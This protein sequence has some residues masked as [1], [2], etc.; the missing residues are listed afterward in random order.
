MLVHTSYKTIPFLIEYM[1]KK[2]EKKAYDTI[3][4]DRSELMTSRWRGVFIFWL[5]GYANVMD[6]FRGY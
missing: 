4:R 1:N 5:G 2:K 6:N 3:T